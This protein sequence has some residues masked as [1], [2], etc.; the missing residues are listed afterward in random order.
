MASSR[1]PVRQGFTLIELLVVIAIIAILIGLLLPAVQ[2]VRES[3]SR[4][5][6]S[7]NLKQ[8]GIAM[9]NCHDVF[10]HFPSGGWGWGWVGEPGRGVGAAQPGGWVYSILPFCEQGALADLGAGEAFGSP[11]HLAAHQKRAQTTPLIFNCP[12]R[13]PPVPFAASYTYRNMT[14]LPAGGLGRTDYAACTGSGAVELDP[15]PTDL[16]GGETLAAN[17]LDGVFGR[18]SQTRIADI[19]KGTSHQLLVGEKYLN[20]DNYLTGSDA[21]DNECMYTGLN[22]DVYRSTGQV[23]TQ[24]RPGVSNATRFGSMHPA[25]ITVVQADGAV[26]QISYQ[27]DATVFR[28][29]GKIA[30]GSV[31]TID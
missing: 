26:R 4:L 6:C 21:G 30:S 29:Y 17:A 19:T 23:P 13:R 24:D 11:A 8:V 3:A 14:S 12:S 20:P 9:H 2:K 27:V 18:K 28:E 7:N 10:G 25:G 15:G 5:K 22:N 31:I 1:R 16:A